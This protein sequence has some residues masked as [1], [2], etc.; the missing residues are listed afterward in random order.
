MFLIKGF[1]L[2]NCGQLYIVSGQEGYEITRKGE[3]FVQLEQPFPGTIVTLAFN[4]NDRQFYTV[5]NLETEE[6]HF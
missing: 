4:L 2:S 6:I 1:I 3:R 5:G